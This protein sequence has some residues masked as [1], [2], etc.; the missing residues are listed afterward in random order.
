[1]EKFWACDRNKENLQLI[2]RSFFIENASE[3]SKCLTL[4][5]DS[6]TCN[7]M[8]CIQYKDG[9]TSN[10]GNLDKPIEEADLRIIPH[11]EDSIQS[12]NTRIVLLSNYTDVLVLV[13]YFMQYFTSIGL[14][15]LWIQFETGQNKRFITV[16]KLSY[17]LGPHTC[18]NL[19][20]AHILTGSDTTGKI[21]M[22]A[23]AIKCGQI[24]YLNNFGL[25]YS[26]KSQF[27]NAQKC[28]VAVLQKNSKSK[29]FDELRYE[30]YIDRRE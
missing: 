5:G 13:L 21:G 11:I 19:F 20:K 23:A 26:I 22:K 16:H 9:I 18:L 4:R 1:M 10:K 2:S 12:K 15:E 30:Q 7:G 28:L 27:E 24:D 17:I 3:N 25:E 14:K 29:N 8:Q 6:D